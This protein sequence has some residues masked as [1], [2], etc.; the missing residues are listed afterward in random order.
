M[1]VPG[2]NNKSAK[3]TAPG[4]S[5]QPEEA[6]PLNDL[7][8]TV[9]AGQQMENEV[10]DHVVEA[11]EDGRYTQQKLSSYDQSN[12]PSIVEFVQEKHGSNLPHADTLVIASPLV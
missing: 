6:M 12:V 3:T 1:S 10:L 9:P 4:K 5:K 7:I 2:S 11:M 8:S